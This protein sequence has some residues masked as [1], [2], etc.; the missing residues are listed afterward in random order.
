M[1]YCGAN[2]GKCTMGFAAGDKLLLEFST[3]GDRYLSIIADVKDDGR[4]LVYAPI[5]PIVVK[6]LR[7]DAHAR[8]RYA[9]GGRLLGFASRVLNKVDTPGTLIELAGPSE[10]FDAEE[11]AEPR[12]ACRFPATVIEGDKA[13][14]AVVEDMSR[15]YSRVRFLN[16][17][18]ESFAD[19]N[20]HEVRLTFYPFDTEGEGYSVWCDVES[21]FMKDG[22]RYALLK[23]KTDQKKVRQR[24]ASFIEAQVCC[25]YPRL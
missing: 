1:V 18:F 10:I 8:V 4:L 2:K 15:S 5:S 14:Q 17:G 22:V 11:R 19:E 24:I 16:G 23:F 12:C 7:N 6:R 9:D 25:G 13:V 3:F 21:A 20:E